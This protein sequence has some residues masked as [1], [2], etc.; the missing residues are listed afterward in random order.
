MR[1]NLQFLYDY[2]NSSAIIKNNINT[3][4]FS[5]L[6]KQKLIAQGAEAKLF[7]ED[8]KIVKDRF[9]KKYRLKQIDSKL[10]KTRTRAEARILEKLANIGFPVPRL[11][12]VDD[13]KAIIAMELIKGEKIRDILESSDYE[14]LCREIGK[15]IAVLHDNN[16]IHHDLTTSNMIFSKKDNIVY[17][18]DFG[19]SFI[20]NKV[21]DR[22][23]DLHLLKQALES[24]HYTIWKRCFKAVLN[25]YRPVKMQKQEVLERF[26]KVESRG[27]YKSK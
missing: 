6:M 19:L 7:L 15:K 3:R 27:R 26:E 21:E 24:K 20:S 25:G 12:D 13:K 17:F 11:L 16:I 14:K 10:R 9:E 22:A 4:F 18:I 5:S 8:E 1:K 23:V 2:Y